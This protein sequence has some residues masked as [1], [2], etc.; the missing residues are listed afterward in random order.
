MVKT[1]TKIIS[2]GK[3]DIVGVKKIGKSFLVVIAGAVIGFIGNSIGVI[4]YGSA[5]TLMATLLPWFAN[6][7]RIWLSKY[8]SA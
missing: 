4:D 3:L 5:T 8:E 6:T 2:N 1:K 7:L